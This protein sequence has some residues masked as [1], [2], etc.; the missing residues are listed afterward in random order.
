[1][2]S[3]FSKVLRKFALIKLCTTRLM[4]QIAQPLKDQDEL[5]SNNTQRQDEHGNNNTSYL[6]I[7]SKIGNTDNSS[8][9]NKH[10]DNT[11][12]MGGLEYWMD[13]AYLVLLWSP[14]D[15][16]QV[17]FIRDRYS[18]Y[19][20]NYCFITFTSRATAEQALLYNGLPIP[21]SSSLFR[22]NWA[23]GSHP[24]YSIFVGDLDSLVTDDMLMELFS[25]YPSL[26][27]AKVVVQ[28]NIS[29]G[30]GF[31]RF[32]DQNDQQKALAEMPGALLLDRAIRVSNATPKAPRASSASTTV[33]VGN[34]PPTANNAVIQ[35][36]FTL[37]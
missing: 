20:A 3:Y 27:S 4:T 7:D 30:Y 18:G 33:F 2:L 8:D 22:L 13:S 1:M 31:V 29:R 35:E 9:D 36:F 16:V 23:L 28:N 24:E 17:K 12:W 14:I 21:G 26:K 11:L 5:D 10:S 15:A 32:K 19:T 37:I 25:R 34:L 6:N